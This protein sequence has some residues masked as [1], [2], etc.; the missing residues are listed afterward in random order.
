[1]SGQPSYK[2]VEVLPGASPHS[3]LEGS[4]DGP[5][6]LIVIHKRDARACLV[7]C[8]A[9]FCGLFLILL[10]VVVFVGR[11]LV[12]LSAQGS[13][14][15]QRAQ[16]TPAEFPHYNSCGGCE[17]GNKSD[18]DLRQCIHPCYNLS[19]VLSWER[20]NKDH[21]FRLVYFPSRAG[22]R[23]EV[24]VNISAWWLPAPPRGGKP[25]P[26]I[27]AM[28][29]VGANCNHCGVQST[30]YLLR[31]MG[32]S[33]LTPSARD[34]GLSGPSSHPDI[35]SWGYDYHLD[36]LGGWDYAVEDPD[37][38]LGGPL[39]AD[40]V[41]IM[42]FSK[43][44]YETA[45][46]LG[47]EQRIPGA[48]L[49]S[50]PYA[51]LFG[52]IVSTV[53]PYVGSFFGDILARGVFASATFFSGGR[54]D[55]FDPLKLLSNCTAGEK[56]RQVLV[57]HGTLDDTV[58]T[59]YSA[60]AIEVLSGE[61]RCYEVR[62]YTPPAYCNGASHHQ[63]MWEFPDDT[64]HKLCSFWSRTFDRDPALCGLGKLPSFQVWEPSDRL[65]PG[66]P[67]TPSFV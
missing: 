39:P 21:E 27:V 20:Y 13:V 37:G 54:V 67:H 11:N 4:D 63:E 6:P 53:A 40:Q 62:T 45:I 38:L 25:A 30:C 46:A 35:L 41:G 5:E 10:G 51:G 48:W 18:D 43:G 44:A 15:A 14:N 58:P 57:A 55:V 52:M 29:G 9:S 65:P 34:A 7:T 3:S 56:K 28:H 32:F 59:R 12:S 1:M 33:C 2:L 16:T 24:P 26:R 22:P 31:S 47:L 64:R 50:G 49:D 61:P 66:S 17:E 36:T 60:M 23:G 42:G 8:L 19:F